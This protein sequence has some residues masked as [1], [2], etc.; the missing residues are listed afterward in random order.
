MK[1]V[2]NAIEIAFKDKPDSFE[3]TNLADYQ[4]LCL[5]VTLWFYLTYHD[6]LL[7]ELTTNLVKD[8]EHQ[9]IGQIVPGVAAQSEMDGGKFRKTRL[10]CM[11]QIR[12]S[13]FKNEFSNFL[14]NFKS[15]FHNFAQ[16]LTC[17]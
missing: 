2:E 3:Y 13:I 14:I 16:I 6:K 17:E 9:C 7:L 10:E 5:Y 11:N 12:K 8:G 1:D 15:Y 4:N